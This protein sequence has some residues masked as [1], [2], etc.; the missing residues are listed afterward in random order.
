MY[1]WFKNAARAV[2]L[3]RQLAHEARLKG[4]FITA[5]KLDAGSV[6]SEGIARVT[7]GK[8]SHVQC[9]IA[10]TPDRMG[11]DSFGCVEPGGAVILPGFDYSDRLLWGA[12]QIPTTSE[13]DAGIVGWSRGRL[14][15][16][17]DFVDIAGI[18]LGRPL[19][20]GN[21][22]ICSRYAV[23]LLQW[24]VGPPFLVGVK[25]A[26]LV[27]PSGFV[28]D[29]HGRSGLFDLAIAAGYKVVA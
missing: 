11:V 23:E 26:C 16:N 5:A 28:G 14:G 19:C 10:N 20:N 6:F 12:V 22:D 8:Y 9:S 24:E 27:S 2:A 3:D 1:L 17:Y 13:Q 29:P 7:G 18:A 21:S 15:R 4:D 25:N